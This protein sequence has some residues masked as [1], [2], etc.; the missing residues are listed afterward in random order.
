MLP[1]TDQ[2]LLKGRR[3]VPDVS[4]DADP[5]TGL[6]FYEAGTWS[7]AG[8]TSAAAPLWSG[9]MAIAD[10]MAGKGLGFI[11]PT[12]Y[13]LAQSSRYAQDFHDITVGN[14]SVHSGSVDVPGY[15]ATTGWDP[16]TGLG[17][18][19]AENLLPDLVNALK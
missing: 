6:V 13:K 10:Q 7:L 1:S 12:L 4:A 19:D 18:P 15:S 17:S 11:N 8:G 9:L 5:L 14:N 16:I 2:S 3:G